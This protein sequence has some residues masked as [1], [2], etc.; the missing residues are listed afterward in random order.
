M[1]PPFRFSQR[2]SRIQPQTAGLMSKPPREGSKA[3]GLLVAGVSMCLDSPVLENG[4]RPEPLER[5]LFL[6]FC[7]RPAR[8]SE[9]M[10]VI[11]PGF[12]LSSLSLSGRTLR[13]NFLKMLAVR[14]N[15]RPSSRDWLFSPLG[16]LGSPVS[17]FSR[18]FP[19]LV[20]LASCPPGLQ[21]HCPLI[22]E[23][24]DFCPVTST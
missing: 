1:R 18:P 20:S 14:A 8:A 17:L 10:G 6:T 24:A 15:L 4:N 22:P 9:T 21:K 13:K 23:A 3:L 16:S 19:V 5:F 7:E 11:Q 2:L 12:S